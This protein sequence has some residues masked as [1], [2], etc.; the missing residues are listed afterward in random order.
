[1]LSIIVNFDLVMFFGDIP[2]RDFVDGKPIRE[3]GSGQ[4][5]TV[6]LRNRRAVPGAVLSI[7]ILAR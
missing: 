2:G 1:M 6:E 5:E 4:L 3:Y 7:D